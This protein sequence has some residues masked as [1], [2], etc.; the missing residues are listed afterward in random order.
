MIA[1][2][3]TNAQAVICSEIMMAED[4]RIMIGVLQATVD[5]E[6][7]KNGMDWVIHC[8]RYVWIVQ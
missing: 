5:R 3:P 8:V 2:Q 1:K 7:S 6:V 4:K